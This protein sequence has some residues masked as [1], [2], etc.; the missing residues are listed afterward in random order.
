MN[1]KTGNIVHKVVMC[2]EANKINTKKIKWHFERR[3]MN[4]RRGKF[5]FL[6][7]RRICSYNFVVV[8]VV[9]VVERKV[10]HSLCYC[11]C[12]CYSFWCC[13]CCCCW[14][15]GCSFVLLLLLLILL[16]FLMMLLLL[17]EESLFVGMLTHILTRCLCVYRPLHLQ[18]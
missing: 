1:V 5:L 3:K 18:T 9:V 16:L 2:N 11:H 6:C 14:D 12:C 4:F 10:V 17:E 15:K 7:E 13:C 8:A